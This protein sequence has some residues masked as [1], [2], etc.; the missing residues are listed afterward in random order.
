V[1]Q[2]S[3]LSEK[4]E[5]DSAVSFT[6][7]EVI[8]F[9]LSRGNLILDQIV[10]YSLSKNIFFF[11]LINVSACISILHCVAHNGIAVLLVSAE[12]KNYL[13]CTRGGMFPQLV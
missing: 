6:V 12:L 4:W 8:D 3:L 5:H 1:F 2:P 7:A 9:I 11:L 10:V 13:I